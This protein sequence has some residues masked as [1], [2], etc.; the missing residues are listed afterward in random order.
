MT[1]VVRIGNDFV[2]NFYEIR[3][4]LKKTRFGAMDTTSI[5]PAENNLDFDLDELTRL[6]SGATEAVLL[7]QHTS[8][9]CVPMEE[10]TR[11]WAIPTWAKCAA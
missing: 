8:A 5:W 11:L 10:H 3:I 7:L 9:K 2:G 1:A 4:P 6:K